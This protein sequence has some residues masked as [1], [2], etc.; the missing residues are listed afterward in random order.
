MTKMTNIALAVIAAAASTT[1]LADNSVTGTYH[2]TQGDKITVTGSGNTTVGTALVNKGL[3]N[4]A[5]GINSS[6]EGK[7][8]VCCYRSSR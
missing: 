5:F 3:S 2:V 7:D 1:V 4:T 6:V 8:S